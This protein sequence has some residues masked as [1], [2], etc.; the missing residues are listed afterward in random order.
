[1]TE[2][3]DNWLDQA[4]QDARNLIE[5]LY[6]EGRASVAEATGDKQ[7]TMDGSAPRPGS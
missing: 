3:N 7:A 4:A 1:M 5:R 6:Q 2:P